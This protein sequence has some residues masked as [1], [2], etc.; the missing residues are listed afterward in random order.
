VNGD[1]Y[2]D[3]LI[4]AS[5]ADPNGVYRGGE[6]Y[7][8]YGGD[9]R[10]Q[11]SYQGTTGNDTHTGTAEAEIIIGGLGND[12]LT[13]GGGKDVIR[14]G[15]GDD[16]IHVGDTAFRGVDGGGGTDT[17]HLDFAGALDLG[18]LHG[19]IEGVEVLD[20]DNGKANAVTLDVT[21]LL[22]IDATDL[23]VGGV[24]GLHDVLKIDGNSGDSLALSSADGWGAADTATLAGYA[25]YTTG[26]VKVAVDTDVTVH[27]T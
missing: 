14:G 8:V 24:S 25:I 27:V 2:D 12:T 1:G 26:A 4:G 5:E 7:I 15:A 22:D 6:A 17:L 21:D 13:G 20:F 18:A 19:K 16:A 9:F 10:G 23:D 3:L 11:V